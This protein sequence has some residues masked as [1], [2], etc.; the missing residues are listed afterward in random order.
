MKERLTERIDNKLVFKDTEA[1]MQAI[2]RLAE[3]EDAEED[4]RLVRLP[5]KVGDKVYRICGQN[6][7]VEKIIGFYI[8]RTEIYYDFGWTQFSVKSKDIFTTREEA[9]KRLAELKGEIK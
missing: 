8:V 4:G 6:I 3:Y 5:C 7:E 2:N 9:E 1:C